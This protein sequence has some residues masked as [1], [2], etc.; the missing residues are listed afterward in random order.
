MKRPSCLL[1]S[2]S[3]V[4]MMSVTMYSSCSVLPSPDEDSEGS[5][6]TGDPHEDY[7][8]GDPCSWYPDQC[9]PNTS[10]GDTGAPASGGSGYPSTETGDT[11]AS[12]T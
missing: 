7:L 4:W 10:S 5:A 11:G 6:E 12:G 2:C 8:D 3:L 1:S 9:G